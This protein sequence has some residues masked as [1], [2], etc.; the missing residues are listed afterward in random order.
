MQ[1][2]G[3][4]LWLGKEI[5]HA[6]TKSSHT[7]TKDPTW[8]QLRRGA[9]EQTKIFFKRTL[10]VSS[11]GFPASAVVKNPPANARDAS[12]IPGLG[13]SPEGGSSNSLQYSCLEN[14]MDRHTRWAT[15]SR[16]CKESDTSKH[17]CIS[18][19]KATHRMR[20]NIFRLYI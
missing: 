11:L 20:E 15:V 5:P 4:N 7:T 2:L 19:K 1:G 13:R 16:G 3:F 14:S 12:S 6:K 8:L 18:S 10:C 17:T 9:A